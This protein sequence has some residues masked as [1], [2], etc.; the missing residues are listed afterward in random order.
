M[1]GATASAADRNRADELERKKQMHASALQHLRD[2]D[3]LRQHHGREQKDKDFQLDMTH[4]KA[5]LELSYEKTKKYLELKKLQ[6]D[7]LIEQKLKLLSAQNANRIAYVQAIAASGL[8]SDSILALQMADNPQ[9]AE[10]Y[11]AAVRARSYEDRLT[12]QKEFEQKLL[13]I[14]TTDRAQVHALLTAGINQI[15]NVMSEAQRKQRPQVVVAGAK[16]YDVHTDAPPASALPPPAE[17]RP[18]P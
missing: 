16:V 11:A 4:D 15:G 8:Q 3:A 1:Q 7:A 12:L 18:N 2:Q 10:A 5:K 17:T 9:L 6:E 14:N 13:T